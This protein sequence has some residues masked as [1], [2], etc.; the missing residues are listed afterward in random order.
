M[1]NIL[2]IMA[3]LALALLIGSRLRDERPSAPRRQER[4]VKGHPRFHAE[5]ERIFRVRV[6]ALE[7]DETGPVMYI[8]GEYS[9]EGESLEVDGVAADLNINGVT[10]SFVSFDP[11]LDD[12]RNGR[13]GDLVDL[14]SPVTLEPC[15]GGKFR[16]PLFAPEREERM[17]DLVDAIY[18]A[19]ERMV[20]KFDMEFENYSLEGESLEELEAGFLNDHVVRELLGGV[21]RE[22][23][24]IAQNASVN[25]T[26]MDAYDDAL[27]RIRITFDLSAEES[28]LLRANIRELA[29]NALRTE[30]GLE[31]AG[32]NAVVFER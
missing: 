23:V 29:L 27:E 20:E 16:A 7:F 6:I 1:E 11:A 5:G 8:N 31:P 12:D 25:A 18:I 2:W 15:H 22:F 10:E 17:N 24:W 21:E 9:L 32:Y 30:L 4:P 26:F 13:I 19:A 14:V 28:G 3:G